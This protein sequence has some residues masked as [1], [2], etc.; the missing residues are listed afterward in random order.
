[1]SFYNPDYNSAVIDPE[2]SDIEY[3]D[4]EFF[5]IEHQII[6]S[7]VDDLSS[8]GFNLSYENGQLKFIQFENERHNKEFIRNL[9]LP[10]KEEII[11]KNI[12]FIN[13]NIKETI[14]NLA[15]GKDCLSSDISPIIEC[16]E[17]QKQKDLFRMLRYTWS[18]PYSEYVGRR[19]KFIIRD[20][21]LPYK[22]VIGIAALGSPIIRIPERDNFIGWNTKTK[23]KNLIYCMDLY[24]CGALPPYSYLLGGKLISYI[25]AS[26]EVAEIYKK[27]YSNTTTI[28]NKKK[29]DSELAAIFTTSLYGKSS[30]YNRIK[31][32]GSLLYQRI[33]QTKGY[34]TVQFSEKTKNLLKEYL[35]L[36]DG[37]V[38]YKFGEGPN[39]NFRFISK[40]FKLLKDYGFNPDLL[41]N[42]SVKRDIYYIPLGSNSLDFLN[43]R[44]EKLNCFNYGIEELSKYWKDRW[45]TQRKKN[46][47]I[48]KNV[49]TFSPQDFLFIGYKLAG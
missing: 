28:I 46:P 29:V 36:K 44:T 45:L 39:Y 47:E 2:S 41:L 21:G 16:C 13:K 38:G 15:N 30:Q 31:Y 35:K 40:A 23:N 5:D 11:R 19:I 14:N 10:R 3:L 6:V 9:L 27:K 26:K 8:F 43:D 49:L 32:N 22:P 42:H 48:I 33:G 24:V 20:G 1:M 25:M 34:G 18:S 7:V 37:K 4:K 12:K 17:T